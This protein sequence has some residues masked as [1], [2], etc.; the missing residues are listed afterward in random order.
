MSKGPSVSAPSLAP[1]LGLANVKLRYAATSGA[2][3]GVDLFAAEVASKLG[4]WPW[5]DDGAIAMN[6]DIR[7]GDRAYVATLSL[8]G[9]EKQLTAPSC[10]LVTDALVASVV[11]HIELTREAVR[12]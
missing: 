3:L 9:A 1:Q 12:P 8:D 5:A 11:A 2:C 4:Y 10:K 7:L 6:V